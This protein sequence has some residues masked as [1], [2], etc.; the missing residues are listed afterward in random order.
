MAGSLLRSLGGRDAVVLRL[1]HCS[2]GLHRRAEEHPKCQ[3]A[4]L[5]FLS[6]VQRAS[7]TRVRLLHLRAALRS[8][9]IFQRNV[10]L[11]F[12]SGEQMPFSQLPVTL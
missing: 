10:C 12:S 2:L 8:V 6:P 9:S 5:C 3:L 4:Q 11:P 1:Q 7:A